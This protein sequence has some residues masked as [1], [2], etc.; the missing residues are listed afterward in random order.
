MRDGTISVVLSVEYQF[1]SMPTFRNDMVIIYSTAIASWSAIEIL[2][3]KIYWD[4][5]GFRFRA[6]LEKPIRWN[7]LVDYYLPRNSFPNFKNELV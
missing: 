6:G 7:L 4:R 5:I 3:P 2:K 1:C